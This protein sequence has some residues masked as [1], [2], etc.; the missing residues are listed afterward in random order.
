MYNQHMGK[1][2][3]ISI[4][5]FLILLG[6]V[7]QAVRVPE[8]TI[9][10]SQAYLPKADLI[11]GNGPEVYILE[12][13]VKRWIPDPETFE[14]FRYKWANVKTIS[15]AF[16]SSYPQGDNLDRYDDYP[17]GTLLK[18]T[19]P[20]V[21]LIEAGQRRWFPN[22]RIF[23]GNNFGWRYIYQIDDDKLNK[24]KQGDNVTLS[25]TNQYP[26]T[27]ILQG[28]AEGEILETAEVTF[29]YSGTNPLGE[30]SDLSFETYLVGHDTRWRNQYSS[31]T[32]TYNLS[33]ESKT[34]TFFVRAKN[35][36]GYA[37]PSPA[38]RTFQIGVSPYYQKVEIRNVYANEDNFRKDYLVLRNN[39]DQ[40][41]NVT[42]WTIKTKGE[43]ITIPRAVERPRHP[44]SGSNNSD[45]KLAYQGEIIISAGLSP[46]GINFRTNKCTGYLDQLSQYHPS[47]DE[48]CPYLDKSEYS[49]LK[50]TCRDFINGLSRCEIPDYSDNLEITLDSQ[51]TGFLTEKFNYS[52]CYQDYEKEVDFLGDKWRVFLGKS[53]DI[54]DNDG[55]T[56]ILRDKNGLVVDEYK[57]D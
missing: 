37:D 45:I 29:K 19:G 52:Q 9:L 10:A 21:Y 40:L 24:I 14:Y 44:F 56:I 41:I 53:I 49:H 18:G 22:P 57:Y 34:Y 28:P 16:L 36:E 43:T 7:F 54:L 13:G 3:T 39:D 38:F 47:L 25:E 8:N 5:L 6:I 23:E 4:L 12:N 50:K 20:E 31:D 11:K 15:D 30:T 33:E 1:I 32:E 46:Q 2:K 17:E 27:I 26:E 48:D 51:C 35:E 55:D 42:G